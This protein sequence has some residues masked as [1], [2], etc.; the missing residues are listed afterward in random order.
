M[1]IALWKMAAKQ[2]ARIK[3]EIR[4]CERQVE[5]LESRFAG[6][7]QELD[8]LQSEIDQKKDA[9]TQAELSLQS[10]DQVLLAQGVDIEPDDYYKPVAPSQPGM[11]TQHGGLAGGAL[12]ALRVA[13]GPMSTLEIADY[14]VALGVV[15]RPFNLT[16][17]VRRTKEALLLRARRGLV[18][19]VCYH[20]KTNNGFNVWALPEYADVPWV[21]PE[22]RTAVQ[23]ADST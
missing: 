4:K 7:K 17:L 13:R 18:V 20:G 12:Q 22:A 5:K 1:G 2:R 21:P 6:L 23:V 10:Y 8:A 19:K 9:L 16:L 11:M 14:V 3:G 15:K